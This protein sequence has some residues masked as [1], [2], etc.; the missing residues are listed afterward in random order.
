MNN[1]TLRKLKGSKISEE[2]QW[3]EVQ[4]HQE[5]SSHGLLR[6]EEGFFKLYERKVLL[7][8]N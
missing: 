7:F 3:R 1:K 5:E 6:Q 2:L 8:T 4:E